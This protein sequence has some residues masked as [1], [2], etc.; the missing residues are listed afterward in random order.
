MVKSQELGEERLE[1]TFLKRN[2]GLQ[3]PFL[4]EELLDVGER[5]PHSKVQGKGGNEL[6]KM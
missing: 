5:N 2:C 3:T 1:R 6:M 4:K